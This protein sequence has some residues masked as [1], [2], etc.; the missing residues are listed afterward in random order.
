LRRRTPLRGREPIRVSGKLTWGFDRMNTNGRSGAAA[1]A[2]R[3]AL[4]RLR[5]ARP[6]WMAVRSAGDALGLDGFTLL[7]AGPPL[8]DPR[9]PCPPLLSSAVLCCLYEGWASDE[10]QA[11]A[12]I[13]SGRVALRPAQQYGA[14]APLAAVISPRASLVE[15]ADLD[16]P[17][18]GRR[19]WSLL[20]SGAGPQIRFGSRDPAI[21]PRMQWRDTILAAG[22]ARALAGAPIELNEPAALGLAGGD[23]LH[24]RT[25]SANA[26]LRERLAPRLAG[27]DG[28]SEIAAM[29]AGTP[30]FFLTLWMAACH[31]ML[32]RAADGG[33]DAA[34][35]LVVALAGNGESVGIRLAGQPSRWFT[36]AAQPPV[37]PRLNPMPQAS[38]SPVIGD[39]GAIDAAGFG[40]QALSFAREVS[41][42]LEPWLPPAWHCGPSRL[43]LG[44]HPAFAG[45]GVRIGL[46]AA[47]VKRHARS[48][49]AAIAMIDAAGEHGLLGRGLYIPPV[50]LFER[51]AATVLGSAAI[52]VEGN[53]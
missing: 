47:A 8:H 2:N 22:L 34:S 53:A 30:L 5:A 38:T 48:P 12:L 16:S 24:A 10:A 6:A 13:A 1:L 37:G 14:V 32:D 26:A 15:I 7:H 23:D 18:A 33:S 51:A 45:L 31:L 21:L 43:L 28:C 39:S 35:T 9:R 44:R 41:A 29:L 4:D 40:G 27:Q 20:G 50:E 11:E 42:A 17:G 19:A 52:C 49:L 46:D 25:S 3:H 36:A